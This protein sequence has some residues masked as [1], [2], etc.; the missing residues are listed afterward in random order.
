MKAGVLHAKNDIRYEEYEKP[1]CGN[2]DVLV[3]VKAVG[4]CG[5][6]LPRVLGDGAHFYPVV[7]GHE[8]SGVVCDIGDEVTTIKVGEKVSGA[9]LLPCHT[10]IDCQKGNHAQCK[11]YSFIGSRQQGAF[12][13]YVAIPEI[14]AVKF[15]DMVSFEQGALFEPSTV[16]LHGILAVDFKGGG[17]VAVLG[18]G[19]IGMFTVQWARIYGAKRVFVFDIDEDRLSL[20]KKIGVDEVINTGDKYFMQKAMDMTN[21]RGFSY[22][23]E[24]AGLNITM[25]MAFELAA[26]K[27]GVCFIGTAHNDLH[28]DYKLF[29][30]VNRKEFTLTGSWMS[31]SAPYPGIEWE[32]TAKCFK[33]G[34]LIYIDEMI[35]KKFPMSKIKDAF[36]LYE[37]PGQV[38]GKILL[39]NIGSVE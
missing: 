13:E 29:E 14:N 3:N 31:Y 33:D 6:D 17:D 22:V 39:T 38:K 20:M 5:S 35:Y 37:K 12:A 16:G 27:A 28:F 7:L 25:N 24:T 15:D 21:G 18:G 30:K 1:I 34:R 23:F 19:T 8:F 26:N 4:I 10:C 32:M 2:T 11:N 9:P 36:A